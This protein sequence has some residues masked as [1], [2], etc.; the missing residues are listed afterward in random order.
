MGW[1]YNFALSPH[2][3]EWRQHRKMAHQHFRA[4][5]A[6]KYLPTQRRKVCDFLQD[7]MVTPEQFHEHSKKYATLL[8]VILHH[9]EMFCSFLRLSIAI[10]LSTMYGYD[11]TSLDDPCIA[12]ADE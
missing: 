5:E 2:N 7:L 8:P 9:T 4:A 12:A 3:D 11:I 1:E 6:V 10:P